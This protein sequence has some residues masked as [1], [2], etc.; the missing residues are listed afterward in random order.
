MMNRREFFV[1]R[2][3]APYWRAFKH[4]CSPGIEVRLG[5]KGDASLIRPQPTAI[6]DVAIAN[7]RIVA[8]QRTSRPAG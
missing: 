5:C 4:A 8:V 6:R 1:L 2:R 7:G 3:L